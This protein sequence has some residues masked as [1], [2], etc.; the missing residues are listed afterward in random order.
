MYKVRIIRASDWDFEEIKEID[1]LDELFKYK[2]QY[3]CNQFVIHF[4]SPKHRYDIDIT[5]YDDYIE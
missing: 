1:S 2:E 3:K 4:N 5:I